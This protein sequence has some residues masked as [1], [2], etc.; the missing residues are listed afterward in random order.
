MADVVEIMA[1][2]I[3]GADC[4]CGKK[5]GKL[6]VDDTGRNAPC[7][8]T[9][10]QLSLG[11]ASERA[12][13]ALSAL[14]AAGYAVVPTEPTVA[15]IEAAPDQFKEAK[16]FYGT[17]HH[18]IMPCLGADAASIYRAMIAASSQY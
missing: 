13:N 14:G 11:L 8:A 18:A 6:C 5:T 9:T 1:R 2:A 4:E 7:R 16:H 3:C 15:M 17:G 10:A 12:I